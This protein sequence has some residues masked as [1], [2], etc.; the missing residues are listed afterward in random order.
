[1][2]AQMPPKEDSSW[3]G[4]LWLILVVIGVIVVLAFFPH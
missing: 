1:M 2:P 3:A 4:C